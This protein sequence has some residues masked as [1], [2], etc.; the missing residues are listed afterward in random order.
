M[1]RQ[2]LTVP[3]VTPAPRR[4]SDK[5]WRDALMI[6]AYRTED[7]TAEVLKDPKAP[8][9]VRAA[10]QC[11]LLAASGDVPALKELGDRFDGKPKQ[12]TEITAGEDADGNSIPLGIAVTFVKPEG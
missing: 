2:E 4:K 8:L 5:I 10:A 3:S 7:E 9:M 1:L 12:Q 11:A 6:A